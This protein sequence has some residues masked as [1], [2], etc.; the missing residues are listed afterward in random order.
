MECCEPSESNILILPL[1]VGGNLL[2]TVSHFHTLHSAVYAFP[3]II[4]I[5]STNLIDVDG[6]S[7][8]QR[9]Y[10]RSTGVTEELNVSIFKLK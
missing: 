8:Y 4:F 3:S 6:N 5:G 1:S 10:S 9:G 2:E 7:C